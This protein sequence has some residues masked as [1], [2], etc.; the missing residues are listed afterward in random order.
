MQTKLNE[1]PL[2]D[3]KALVSACKEKKSVTL[4]NSLHAK[5]RESSEALLLIAE[6]LGQAE[7]QLQIALVRALRALS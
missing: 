4:Q 6:S 5:D 1:L 3:I 2:E 7:V